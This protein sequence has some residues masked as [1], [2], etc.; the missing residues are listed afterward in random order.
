[1]IEDIQS[2]ITTL[3]RSE[4]QGQL[5]IRRPARTYSGRY[6]PVS[7]KYP[8]PASKKTLT[9][10]LAQSVQ[11]YFKGN[12]EDDNLTLYV[13]FGN[14]DYWYYVDQ[15]RKPGLPVIKPRQKMKKDGT[16]GDTFYVNDFT[17]YPPLSS[18]LQW[19]RQRP[20]LQGAG[21]VNTRAYLA[22][23]SIAQYGIYGIQFI[24][25]ALENIEEQVLELYGDLGQ[26]IFLK[27]IDT[28]IIL[29]TQRI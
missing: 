27:I 13:D 10:N 20:A 1:M 25:G 7:K 16:M 9:G 3:L 11:V 23:R 18:I 2:Q 28:K 22:S 24:K 12:A 5:N 26:E 4:I 21:D 17:K 19:V 6:K 15:G 29:P 14:T 8:T